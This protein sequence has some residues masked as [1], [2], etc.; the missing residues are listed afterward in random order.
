MTAVKPLGNAVRLEI[1]AGPPEGM[2]ANLVRNPDGALGGWGWVTPV[3]GST[4]TGITGTDHLPKLLFSGSGVLALEFYTERLTVGDAQYVKAYWRVSAADSTASLRYSVRID[5]LDKDDVVLVSSPETAYLDPTPTASRAWGAYAPPAH[6]GLITHARLRFAVRYLTGASIIPNGSHLALTDVAVVAAD[7]SADADL[8]VAPP[9]YLY[10]NV[11]GTTHDLTI[12]RE[13]LNVGTLSANIVDA[14]L[15]PAS[16]TTIRPGRLVRVTAWDGVYWQPVFTGQITGA[17][18]EYALTEPRAERRARIDLTA[19]DNAQA[20]A[21]TTSTEGVLR[22]DQLS[23]VLEG[24]SP[25]V[26]WNLNGSGAQIAVVDVVE[27]SDS[28]SAL[29]QVTLTRDTNLG[30]AW[31]DRAG[32]VQ[33]WDRDLM[34]TAPALPDLDEDTYADVTVGYDTD[35]AVNEVLVTDNEYDGIDESNTVTTFGPYRDETSIGTWGVHRAEYRTHGLEMIGDAAA[36]AADVLAANAQPVVQLTAMRLRV[37]LVADWSEVDSAHAF[38]DLYDL[39]TVSCARAAMDHAPARVVAIQHTISGPESKWM[40]TLGFAAPASTAAAGRGARAVGDL[41][42]VELPTV[43]AGSNAVSSSSG[44]G[45]G[46]GGAT[47]P[48]GG[49]LTGSYPNPQIGPLAV[50][51]AELAA[52]AVTSAKIADGTIATADLADGA[53]TS[54]KILDGAVNSAKIADGSVTMTDLNIAVVNEI[55]NSQVNAYDEGALVRANLRRLYF[56]GA[57]VTVTDNPPF[58]GVDVTIPG[59]GAPTGAAGGDLAGTYPNPTIGPLKVTT[60]SLADGAVTSAK[61]ADATIGAVDLADGAVTTAKVADANITIAKMAPDTKDLNGPIASLRSLGPTA[62]QA[63]PG[64]H[65]HAGTPPSAHATT[66][67]P[68]GSDPMAV[69]A[70]TGTGS[71]RT[72]GNGAF[73]A[74]AGDH[75]HRLGITDWNTVSNYGTVG[76]H[77]T[78]RFVNTVNPS[79][80]QPE[81]GWWSGVY[82]TNTGVAPTVGTL[83]LTSLEKDSPT[84]KVWR[85]H[86][87][88]GTGW[89]AWYR[90]VAEVPDGSITSAKIADGTVAFD[91]LD[92]MTQLRISGA[93]VDIDD[94]GVR[95]ITNPVSLNFVGAGVTVTESPTGVARVDIPGG[96]GSSDSGWLAVAFVAPFNNYGGFRPA[97]Y[98]KVGSRVD[99]R[100]LISTAGAAVANSVIFNLPVGFRPSANEL[101]PSVMYGPGGIV[102]TAIRLNVFTNGAVASERAFPGTGGYLSLSSCFFYAD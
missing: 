37:D 97:Q 19:V 38:V 76:A 31:V 34:P 11:L 66:H 13:R 57:G 100:G 58:Y 3:A 43:A 20:L 48:A 53:V 50:G 52:N 16:S 87:T 23:Y 85:R 84:R 15:D 74:A 86:Y 27:T 32:V 56:N 70:A 7:T 61:I 64:N 28:T 73:Q 83:T 68:G 10:L 49:D 54:N 72:L 42:P 18:V 39:V 55:G 47:G 101:L 22:V 40:V 4:M 81:A 35:N 9:D 94:E 17:S 12:T 25:A 45:G 88:I 96:G 59:G 77:Q 90:F 46:G 51:T 93:P 33:A 82:E 95:L 41:W 65:T 30:Y 92:T 6:S 89:G 99:M 1:E 2:T 24:V 75:N 71:L 14:D 69:D 79:T 91:D 21:N 67:Q 80:N 98:R 26:P 102:D 8:P 29:D 36:Y 78:Y 44:G 63:A 62:T 5:W 60:P